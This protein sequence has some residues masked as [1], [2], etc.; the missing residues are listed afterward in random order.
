MFTNFVF[1]FMIR[2]CLISIIICNPYGAISRFIHYAKPWCDL[3][4]EVTIWYSKP[5]LI[6]IYE[7]RVL[8]HVLTTVACQKW[9]WFPSVLPNMKSQGKLGNVFY[10]LPNKNY[11]WLLICKERFPTLMNFTVILPLICIIQNQNSETDNT[12]SQKVSHWSSLKN[13]W[14]LVQYQ[15][16]YVKKLTSYFQPLYFMLFSYLKLGTSVL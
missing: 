16:K 3:F 4:S 11:N 7:T 6:R 12:R 10:H 2:P 13:N 15:T 14:M 1:I 5:W 8:F 9:L